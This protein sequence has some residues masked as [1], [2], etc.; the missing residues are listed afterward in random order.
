M[1]KLFAGSFCCF[2]ITRHLHIVTYVMSIVIITIV[3]VAHSHQNT[4]N[5][6]AYK[7]RQSRMSQTSKRS[8]S[9]KSSRKSVWQLGQKNDLARSTCYL[10]TLRRTLIFLYTQFCFFFFPCHLHKPAGTQGSLTSL[11]PVCQSVVLSVHHTFS[12][13]AGLVTCVFLWNTVIQN[14]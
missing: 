11:S 12:C 13:L 10:K 1:R 14:G 7:S 4:F 9:S 6:Y 8:R 3:L 2:Q 5:F